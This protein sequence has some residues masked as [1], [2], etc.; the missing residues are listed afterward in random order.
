M[1]PG[2]HVSRYL[3]ET[4]IVLVFNAHGARGL[5]YFSQRTCLMFSL[6]A[7]FPS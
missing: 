5:A 6:P 3:V 2:M 1:S 4:P 7:V